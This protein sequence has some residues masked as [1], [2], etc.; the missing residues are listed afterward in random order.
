MCEG[1]SVNTNTNLVKGNTV[2]AASCG[3]KADLPHFPSCF[4]FCHTGGFSFGHHGQPGLRHN[5]GSRDHE[6]YGVHKHDELHDSL[7]QQKRPESK[8]H[9]S[10]LFGNSFVNFN[11]FALFNPEENKKAGGSGWPFGS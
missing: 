5:H 7:H 8:Q 1:G 2:I 3:T 10:S 4:P 11:P 6:H 9:G